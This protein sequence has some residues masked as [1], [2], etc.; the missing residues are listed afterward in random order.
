LKEYSQS[1]ALYHI[2]K[3]RDLQQGNPIA[4]TEIQVDLEAYCNDNCNFCSYRK[5]DGVNNTMLSLLDGKTHKEN[6]PIGKPTK[7]SGWD[8]TMAVSLPKQMLEAGIPAIEITGGGESTL[9][10]HF[11]EL[12]TNLGEAQR[13]IALVTNGSNLSDRRI[14]LIC[15]Y[16]LWVR[17]SMDASNGVLHK[18]IH[19]T[20]NYDF[21]RRVSNIKKIIHLK[22]KELI[23]G[24]SF[25]I[26]QENYEDIEES[27]LFYHGL[28][29]DNIRF[30][31]M[32]DSSGTS[33]LSIEQIAQA[34]KL[35]DKLQDKL[36]IIHYDTDRTELYTAPNDDFD[37]CHF[38]RFVW[39][40]GADMKVYPCCIMKYNPNFAYGDLREN[41]LKELI[42]KMHESQTGL[43]PAKC[44]PCWLRN[45]NK[46]I[47]N[48]VEQPLHHNFI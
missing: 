4:P 40:I 23:L 17:I 31:W 16:C 45:K 29:V 18:Q 9:W 7:S 26:N 3:I 39:S 41:T 48:A 37:T 33:G 38:Q 44:M 11:D 15:K 43:V 13:D 5:E 2:D 21:D 34:K 24:I 20:A 1:K 28:G 32:Y 47:G 19:R 6:K 36:G 8:S 12:L 14:D 22:P 46:A 10:P 30:S 35:L 25:I 27:A 42:D